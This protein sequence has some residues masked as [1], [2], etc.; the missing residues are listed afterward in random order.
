MAKTTRYFLVAAG[1]VYTAINLHS[2]FPYPIT[3][4]VKV[5]LLEVLLTDG[6]DAVFENRITG[7]GNV[8]EF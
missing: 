4:I 5:D 2:V 7:N 3:S 8:L 6:A 1:M